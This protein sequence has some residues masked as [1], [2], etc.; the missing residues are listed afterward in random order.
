M[1]SKILGPVVEK[2]ISAE[3]RIKYLTHGFVYNFKETDLIWKFGIN[4]FV[5]FEENPNSILYGPLNNWATTS[6][7]RTTLR[8]RMTSEKRTTSRKKT[9]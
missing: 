2:P 3:P 5:F 8:T 1:L 7:T 9:T 6:R 4:K